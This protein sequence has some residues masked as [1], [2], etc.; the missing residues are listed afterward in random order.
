MAKLY[1]FQ[2]TVF[3]SPQKTPLPGT[4]PGIEEMLNIF[5][6]SGFKFET[7]LVTSK[8]D[9]THIARVNFLL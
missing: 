2:G 9:K 7:R 8:E 3:C 1:I 5:L 4:D 6:L